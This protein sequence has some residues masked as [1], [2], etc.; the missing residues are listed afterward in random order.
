MVIEIIPLREPVQAT[1]ATINT[2]TILPN[3]PGT[4]CLSD[5]CI[6]QGI[7]KTSVIANK[8]GLPKVPEA[9]NSES[10]DIRPSIICTMLMVDI[11]NA[12]KVKCFMYDRDISSLMK[13]FIASKAKK[14]GMK[15]EL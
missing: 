6:T 9:L 4:N 2:L 3:Q 14:K 8:L 13:R 15:A 5:A 1:P 11:I 7:A 12:A 10:P